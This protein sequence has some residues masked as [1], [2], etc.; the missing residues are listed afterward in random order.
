MGNAVTGVILGILAFALIVFA[1]FWATGAPSSPTATLSGQ[2]NPAQA[3]SLQLTLTSQVDSTIAPNSINQLGQTFVVTV[4][5]SNANGGKTTVLQNQHVV[6]AAQV[7]SWP[8]FN[9]TATITVSTVAVCSG[10][11]CAGAISNITVTAQALTW[12]GGLAS[13]VVTMTFSSNSAYTSVP[14]VGPVNSNSYLEQFA[15]P[16]LM[17]IGIAILAVSTTFV[18]HKVGYVLGAA[19][20]VFGVVITLIL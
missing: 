14:A 15:G 13:P 19:L 10:S 18:P 1:L 5:E 16:L 8:T 12:G 2:I 17:G 20:V 3:Q 6:A 11:S 4:T 7:S 9:L